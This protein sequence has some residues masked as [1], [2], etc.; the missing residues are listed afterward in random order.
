[1]RAPYITENTIDIASDIN[2]SL[3]TL[4]GCIPMAVDDIVEALP[5]AATVPNGTILA[6]TDGKLYAVNETKLYWRQCQ[7]LLIVYNEEL[8]IKRAGTWALIG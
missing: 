1:M 3:R 6:T 5:E 2:E 4:D 8:Y 7:S